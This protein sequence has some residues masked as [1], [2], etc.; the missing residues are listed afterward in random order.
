MVSPHSD[1]RVFLRIP[2]TRRVLQGP[3]GVLDAGEIDGMQGSGS[4]RAKIAVGADT[5][6]FDMS[7][8]Q[9]WSCSPELAGGTGGTGIGASRCVGGETW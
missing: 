5:V 6:S 2:D 4:M 3:D 7:L 9:Q 1:D 8:S